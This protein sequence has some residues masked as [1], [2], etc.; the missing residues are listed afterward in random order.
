MCPTAPNLCRFSD[1]HTLSSDGKSLLFSFQQVTN[2]SLSHGRGPHP[3]TLLHFPFFAL[4]GCAWRSER[5]R[6]IPQAHN[7]TQGGTLVSDFRDVD[8]SHEDCKNCPSRTTAALIHLCSNARAAGPAAK[9]RSLALSRRR[10]GRHLSRRL[11]NRLHRPQ[12]RQAR[13]PLPA[14][15]DVRR[16]HGSHRPIAQRRFSR[17]QSCLVP[18]QPLDRLRGRSRRQARTLHRPSRRL[19]RHIPRRSQRHQCSDSRPG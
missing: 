11:E 19:W 1:L 9:Q 8:E 13:S 3:P 16:R 12:L 10:T 4:C 15:L 18:R 7:R 2:S 14:H 17:R 6:F 5:I